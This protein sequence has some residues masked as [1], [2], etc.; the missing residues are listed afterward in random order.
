MINKG[1]IFLQRYEIIEPIGQGGMST[2]YKGK[3]QKLGRFVAIKVLK[4]EYSDNKEFVEKFRVEAQAA[5]SLS[6]EN[7]VNVYDVG[8][9]E[10]LHFI[11]MEYLEG[12]TLKQYIRQKD[13]LSEAETL[14]IAAGIC[15]ALIH[16]HTHHI[17]HR[18]IKPQ[19]I[20]IMNNGKVK[21]AD[22]GI[23]R[24]ATGETIKQTESLSG[25]VYYISP[26]QARGSYQNAASDIY[27]LGITMYEML[28]GKLPFDGDTPINVALKHVSEKVPSVRELEPALSENIEAI[29]M[30]ATQKKPFNR[31]PDVD[32][33]L[34]DINKCRS[35]SDEKIQ[36]TDYADE[37]FRSETIQVDNSELK[38]IWSKHDMVVYNKEKE[39]KANIITIAAIGSALLITVL[40]FYFIF[41]QV[42]VKAIPKYAQ[43]P[44]LFGVA[45]LEAEDELNQLQLKISV[46]EERYDSTIAQGHIIS[47]KPTAERLL[48]AGEEV[49][50]VVSKGE[51]LINVPA[52]TNLTS[53][54]ATATLEEKDFVVKPF[55]VDSETVKVGYVVSQSPLPNEKMAKGSTVTISVSNGPKIVYVE[56]L[57]VK[58]LLLSEATTII[59]RQNLEVGNVSYVYSDVIEKDKVV[60]MSVEPNELVYEGYVI[61]LAV[62]KGPKIVA[63]SKS[64]IINDI[65]LDGQES[66]TLRVV[67]RSQG[68]SYDIYNGT[69]SAGDFPKKITASQLGSG[70]IH[71]YNDEEQQYEFYYEFTEE[72]E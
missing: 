21:V 43:V 35:N 49:E 39:P 46:Q 40:I 58:N 53:Q 4:Q 52:V 48:L 63:V 60:T 69:V 59:T 31:Y 36:Y 3:D 29:I 11:V 51:E 27:S 66:C 71:V 6:H 17:I 23:A 7:I 25:S 64:F 33:L 32:Q 30:R 50:V 34:N 28:T 10:N 18:D 45:L 61:D 15:K 56:V 8:E 41:N 68:K 37:S 22:F 70:T 1:I 24:V 57:D 16:A 2:V 38:S 47:Q 19:N 65:L 54:E 12:Q 42:A 14:K 62:S 44:D 72:S 55:I 13:K 67:Y 9:E 20:M 5:A 26:E